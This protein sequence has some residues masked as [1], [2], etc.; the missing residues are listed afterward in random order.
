MNA[1][2][3]SG[4]VRCHARLPGWLLLAALLLTC[5]PRAEAATFANL[6]TVTVDADPA[7]EDP[8][9]DAIERAMLH[10]LTRVTGRRDPGSYPEIVPI[11]EA[12]ES[13]YLTSYAELAG[14]RVRIGFNGSG[15]ANALTALD[16]PLWGAERPATLVWTAI[17]FGDG[18]RAMLSSGDDL[19]ALPEELRAVV[20]TVEE[21]LLETADLRGLPIILPLLDAE[22]LQS[23][24]FA[25]IWGGFDPLIDRAS[26]RY[27]PDAV[28]V[29][30]VGVTEFGLNVRWTLLR[31]GE[32]QLFTSSTLSEGMDWLADVYAAEY[33]SIGGARM[34]R[35]DVVGVDGF[36]DYGRVVSYLESVSLLETVDIDSVAGDVLSLRVVARGDEAVLERVLR[37][38]GVLEQVVDPVEPVGISF[39]GRPLTFRLARRDG[40]LP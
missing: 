25:E 15:V 26:R 18:Q 29:A 3:A 5:L 30:R 17:D 35:L 31:R 10:L 16:W 14:G 4:A 24:G 38:D 7:A 1:I 39:G 11:V 23:I 37:L 20:Q 12:A 19:T 33:S 13:R 21:E 2:R 8:R 36:R 32:R 27:S 28:L 9:G 34:T 40:A 22:D 6:Y